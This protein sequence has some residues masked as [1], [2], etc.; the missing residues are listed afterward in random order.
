MQKIK[1]SELK[2]GK[3]TEQGRKKISP[4]VKMLSQVIPA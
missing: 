4:T 1:K 2:V 3:R